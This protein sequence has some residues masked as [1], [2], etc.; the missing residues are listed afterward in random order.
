ME[1][2]EFEAE[3]QRQNL[4]YERNFF[5]D[6][7]AEIR[8]SLLNFNVKFLFL[9]GMV[10]SVFLE[11]KTMATSQVP[12]I[13]IKKT[14]EDSEYKFEFISEN[15]F[16]LNMHQIFENWENNSVNEIIQ[17]VFLAFTNLLE[18][19]TKNYQDFQQ[20][21]SFFDKWQIPE[22]DT[23]I[24]ITNESFYHW[25]KEFPQKPFE[26]YNIVI[27]SSCTDPLKTR[28]IAM[29]LLAQEKTKEPSAYSILK[30]KT[31]DFLSILKE[32]HTTMTFAKLDN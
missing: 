13:F 7:K 4:N 2:S 18:D 17:H 11:D 24:E 3:L 23:F 12:S 6:F 31:D 27:I 10:E 1:I 30:P 25:F 16:S 28:Y 26:P 8:I 5:E 21:S 19:I 20:N 22:N 15:I 14:I 9:N 29:R 32:I